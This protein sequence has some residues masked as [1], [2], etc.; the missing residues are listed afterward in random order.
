M[1]QLTATDNPSPEHF[2]RFVDGKFHTAWTMRDG[3]TMAGVFLC[4]CGFRSPRCFT[5]MRVDGTTCHV[6][7]TEC[8]PASP[9]DIEWAV[10]FYSTTPLGDFAPR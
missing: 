1:N 5:V 4:Y 3:H 8:K 9:D 10:K 2:S 6:P 7:V